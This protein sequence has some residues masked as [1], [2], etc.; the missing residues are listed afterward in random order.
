MQTQNNQLNRLN[1][2]NKPPINNKSK[3]QAK[4]TAKPKRI[5]AVNTQS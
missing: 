1:K 3:H 2:A 5:I 4:Q